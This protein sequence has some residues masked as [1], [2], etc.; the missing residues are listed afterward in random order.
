MEPTLSFFVVANDRHKVTRR[1]FSWVHEY[2]HILFDRSLRGTVS[3]VSERSALA[4]VRANSFAASFL[5]PEDGVWGFIDGIGKGRGSRQRWEVYD[6]SDQGRTVAAEGRS[7]PGSQQ[8]QLYDAVLLAHRYGVSRAMV[9]YRLKNVGLINQSELEV[10]LD[11]ERQQGWQLERSLGLPEWDAERV[12]K[13]AGSQSGETPPRSDFRTRF[14]TLA[15][16]AYRRDKISRGKLRTLADLVDLP[17]SGLDRLL[18]A[19]G[20]EDDEEDEVL[21]PGD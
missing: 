1:R 3:R 19:S 9:L 10:L 4:E 21:L 17:P 12:E 6:E 20:L 11:Q 13:G 15:L 8:I 7:E 18:W 5:V 2:A 14:L 16:E